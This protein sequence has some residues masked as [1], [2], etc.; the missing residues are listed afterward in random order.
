M[1]I[2]TEKRPIE[3]VCVSPKMIAFAEKSE[4]GR[5]A[6]KMDDGMKSGRKTRKADENRWVTSES[7]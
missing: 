4:S 7:K 5:S 2:A 6:E 3:K 1:S